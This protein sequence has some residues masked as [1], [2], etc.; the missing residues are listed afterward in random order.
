VAVVNT[1]V[2]ESEMMELLTCLMVAVIKVAL[3]MMLAL[4]KV[5]VVVVESEMM[6]LSTSSESMAT[7]VKVALVMTVTVVK[8]EEVELEMMELPTCL[9]NQ[10]VISKPIGKKINHR[11]GTI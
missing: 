4:T 10:P 11:P 7:V 3:K 2:V 5:V 6:K 8:V 1:A 9:T